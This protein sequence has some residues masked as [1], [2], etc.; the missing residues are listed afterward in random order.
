LGSE[1]LAEAHRLTFLA[2]EI[3][4]IHPANLDIAEVMEGLGTTAT[5]LKAREIE[6]RYPGN[7]ARIAS[8]PSPGSR[9]SDGS[10]AS[11]PTLAR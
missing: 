5:G 6:P 4:K 9:N 3:G 1:G 8:L 10:W 11:L 2:Y 7:M